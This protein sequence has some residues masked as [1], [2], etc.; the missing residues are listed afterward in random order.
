MKLPMQSTVPFVDL[1]AQFEEIDGE[2]LPLVADV[3]RRGSYVGG[4]EITDFESAYA[5]YLGAGHCVGVGNGTDA[6]EIAMLTAGIKPQDEV[7]V[8]AN[9]FIAT[10]EAVVRIGA[11][12]VL[13][14]V[15]EQ[16]LLMSPQDVMDK[17][18][19]RTAAVIPVHLFGQVA[20][21]EKL[22]PIAEGIGAVVIEDA[23]QAQGA[24][25][26]GKAA[27]TWGQLSATSF[28]PGKNLGAAGD[29]GAVLTNDAHLARQ[30]RL[31]GAHGS[32]IKYHHEVMGRNSRL[33]T[34]QAVILHAKLRRLDRWNEM[35]RQ[36]AQR[37]AELLSEMDGV[38]IP[39]SM[40]G[41]EDVWHLYVVR[42]E[43]RDEVSLNMQNL[44][45]ST[46]VH[47][48]GPINRTEAWKKLDLGESSHPVAE[49][50]SNEILSLPLYPHITA[51][52]QEQVVDALKSSLKRRSFS[53]S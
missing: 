30:V 2:V 47:Y 13:V 6:L 3:L 23:A 32:E 40:K 46:G 34:I 33:D 18:T 24:R 45:I 21:V 44:G 35:R 10:V 51:S 50:A 52:Q 42:V 17:A 27:G 48:P 11:R 1:V 43:N 37:Y 7:L 15:D 31:L 38:R 5:D 39:Q 41:N 28:Y 4:R 53:A 8:P 9:T 22:L 25:R 16:Y 26:L 19:A 14:D 12:P 29:A 20:P 49:A 36:A